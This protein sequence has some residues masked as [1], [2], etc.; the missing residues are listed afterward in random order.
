MDTPE[1]TVQFKVGAFQGFVV[2]PVVMPKPEF[3]FISS[4]VVGTRPKG[5]DGTIV[6]DPGY[7]GLENQFRF[8]NA[9]ND[10]VASPVPLVFV[11]VPLAA[12][13]P[14]PPAFMYPE[15]PDILLMVI[16]SV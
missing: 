10:I 1:P 12:G 15:P 5:T 9:E 13:V 11:S 4:A 3:M 7:P 8:M 14:V 2:G 16:V 6:F